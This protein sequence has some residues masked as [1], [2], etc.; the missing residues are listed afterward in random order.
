MLA[1]DKKRWNRIEEL[2]ARV[3]ECPPGDRPPR[4]AEWC[5]GDEAL[6]REVESLLDAADAADRESPAG[7][8]P[9]FQAPHSQDP[10]SHDPWIGRTIGAYRLEYL[11]ARGGMGAVYFARRLAGDFDQPAAVKRISV[12]I[13]G[14]WFRERFLIE[15]QTLASLQHRN[16]ARVLDGGI[17]EDGEPYV[18]MEYVA[19]R[20]LDD[21]CE[22]T[23]A[24][25]REIVRLFLQLCDA[26]S[27]VHRNLIVHRDLK[28]GNV[29]VT[30]EG[31]VKLLDFG[32]A[33]L[34]EQDGRE[35][36]LTRMGIRPL[37]P[38]YASP[39]QTLGVE[40]TTAS[41]VYSLGVILYRLLAG[42]LPFG[43]EAQFENEALPPSKA[44]A[45]PRRSQIRGDLDAVVLK[46]LR[47]NPK[48]RYRSVDDLAADL[49]H[50]LNH[51][52]VSAREG[53]AFYRAGRLIRR[54]AKTVA[55]VAAILLACSAMT[56]ATVRQ[57]RAATV[58]AVRA[59]NGYLEMRRLADFLLFDFY[60]QARQ[61][62]GSTELQR[63]LVSQGLLYLDSLSHDV[64]GDAAL[65]LDL[66][67][68][69]TKMGNVLGN[70]YEE[71]LGEAA[72]AVATLNKAV[73][74]ADET[75][76]RR[77]DDDLAVRRLA[78][79]RRSLAEVYFSTGDTAR[80]IE[81]CGVAVGLLEKLAQ[82]TGAALTDIQET[83]SALGTL[84]D[85]HG[86]HGTA[87]T[88]DLQAA[89]DAYRRSVDF[90]RA[91]L[92]IVPGNVRSL[93]GLAVGQMKIANVQSDS[94]PAQAARGYGDALATLELL[95][96]EVRESAP[97][98]RVA[99]VIRHKLANLYQSIDQPRNALPFLELACRRGAEAAQ[100]DPQD[101][102]IRFDL[103]T[104]YYDLG[105]VRASLGDTTAAREAF[106]EVL[107][108]VD[109]LLARDASNLVWV[110]HRSDALF[111]LG[112]LDW[113]AGEK[114]SGEKEARE[115]LATALRLADSPHAT[116]EDF[117][118]AAD[119]F[120]EINPPELRRPVQAV[121][122]A[123][124]AVDASHHAN[125]EFL[126]TLA[127]AQFAAGQTQAARVTAQSALALLPRPSAGE[128]ETA[129]RR[130]AER[131]LSAR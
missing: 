99:A 65:Q 67:D 54:R 124:R 82:R 91:A 128:P 93:R 81:Q 102:R 4:L 106:R 12:R 7:Q 22:Q 56:I 101:T 60:D 72:K 47:I 129:E 11:I 76:R 24:S 122:F 8:A 120:L 29:L 88:G 25:V 74:I 6:R 110:A 68:A 10:L 98:R 85:M 77:P 104:D 79:A 95:P 44:A 97:I 13:T 61:L 46:A 105:A 94:E 64:G 115:A 31:M 119:D 100:R 126:I 111:D 127:R 63:Q 107:R 130:T 131:M 109:E 30:G 123:N 59:Q 113:R 50:Y 118:R 16:I 49:N 125:P 26:V 52:P 27:F 53:G 66:A 35:G 43:D 32:A 90:Q 45:R 33:K 78:I 15:R 103:A 108:T 69:Y 3:S 5:E 117:Q 18:V 116:G 89:L 86:L 62:Q 121:E 37:T 14:P 58:E 39:E 73:T 34:L 51:R 28:P 87:S 83:A 70:P 40:V 19:G 21:Y 71:N 96:P 57:G 9:N 2:F 55:A 84:G 20:R 41:D 75:V 92:K 48:E 38:Q 17:T 1:E 114:Q 23:N 112:A 42:S 80:A 36:D